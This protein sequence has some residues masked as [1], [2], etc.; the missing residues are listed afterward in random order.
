[1]LSHLLTS[2]IN[3]IHGDTI[4]LRKL[5][6]R[7]GR[8]GMLLVCAIAC[9]P[10]LIPVSIPGVS[11]VFGAA[12]V[13]LS[14]ALFL[15]RLPWLPQR[16]LDKDLDANKLKPVLH[17]GVGMVGKLD[18]WLQ[19]R[20]SGLTTSPMQRVN[21]AVLV[22]GGLLLMAPLGLIPFSN[23]VPAVGILLLTVGMMQRD[24]VFVLLGYLGHVLTVVY[25]GVLAY[26]AWVGGNFVLS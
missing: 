16:I 12:I 5:L 2:I 7:C 11:T 26:L 17:K 10:F 9:L 15:D 6:E 19:P 24:G 21:S 25:F 14:T 1:M 20:W 8:E 3:D 23:T 4:T 18:R 22:F 13:L